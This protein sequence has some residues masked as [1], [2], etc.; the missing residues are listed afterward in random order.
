MAAMTA[1]RG[2]NEACCTSFYGAG[3]WR[4]AGSGMGGGDGGGGGAGASD[5]CLA[6]RAL[7]DIRGCTRR[8]V[9]G[10]DCDWHFPSLPA[11]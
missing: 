8:P 3:R 7:R 5:R 2:C 9:P 10:D 4:G 6:P 11:L 1:R